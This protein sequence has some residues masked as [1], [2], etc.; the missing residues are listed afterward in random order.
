MTRTLPR[1]NP[2]RAAT[3]FLIAVVSLLPALP[4]AADTVYLDFSNN[5]LEN[6]G[7]NWNYEGWLIVDG[8]PVSTGVFAIDENGMVSPSRFAVDVN[9]AAAV[10]SFVLTIEPVPDDDPTPSSVHILASDFSN[11]MA[12]LS[13]GHAAA[14]GDDFTAAMGSYILNA[15][16][17]GGM[18]DYNN[19]IWW[20][21]PTTGPGSTLDLPVL[22]AGWTYEG[23]VVG[24]DGPRSTGRFSDPTMVDSDGQGITGGPYDAP[25]LPGQDLVN[26][27]V[28]LT[29]GY[30][31]VLTIEPD[32]DNSPMPFT[33][34][35]LVDPTID[36]VGAGVLQEMANN[37]NAFPTA[38]VT[39]HQAMNTMET[40]HVMLD[41]QGLEDLGPDAAYEGWLIVD[42]APVSTGTFTVA[43]GILSATY[44][45]TRVSSLNAIEAFVLTIEPVPDSDPSP[46]STHLLGGDVIGGRA[47]LTISH[48]A[49]LGTDF[50]TARGAYI[51]NAPSS[52]GSAPYT[53]GIWWLDP[54]AG[55]G[56]TLELPTL[57]DGWVY[58]GWV[59]SAD[60]PV[61]TG[62]FTMASGIDSDGAGAGSGSESFPPFPGQDFV[63][64]A[65]DL[66]SGFAA[67]ISVEPEPD[68]SSAPFTIKPL[69][70]PV[71]DDLG[72]GIQQPMHANLG[73]LPSGTV[74]LATTTTIPAAASTLG[75]AGARWFTDLDIANDGSSM[76]TVL[77]QLLRS[78]QDNPMPKSVA[79]N[80]PAGGA[81]R[82]ED[83]LAEVFDFTGTSA[84][85]I[86]SDSPAVRANSRTYA[87]KTDGSYGQGVPAFEPS[88]SIGFGQVGRLL[89]LSEGETFRTNIGFVNAGAQ[90]V[91]VHLE[92]FASDGSLVGTRDL[93]LAANEHKQ[94]NHVYPEDVAI[95]WARVSTSTPGGSFYA[96]AS[97]IDNGVDDPTFIVAQ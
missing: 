7:P 49:A 13:A 61:T 75:F 16:S 21:D 45:P 89:Q 5:G 23:W 20:L 94:L 11:G 96:Y 3:A 28:D 15:P 67:V 70:D 10:S 69:L 71:I 90:S 6:L 83:V 60:G 72:A 33:F 2:H 42:G 78:N 18:A 35:P 95:G 51:L 56:P 14:L 65:M 39:M 80:L 12:M 76:A 36:D 82:Y 92:L 44:F 55:P 88:Q 58:E 91:D 34:K 53:N 77:I 29:A 93:T 59:A 57:P 68:N 74:T 24:A 26:P 9:D 48:N 30:A 4:A 38:T 32:P 73:N 79:F 85:R 8:S 46:S 31:A 81:M 25:Q 86:V 84:L 37:A 64:P 41:F 19:G 22:P 1:I 87:A 27:P 66:S 17:G 47:A 52:G 43:G 62:R 40:A 63:N 54:E 50:S 97:V